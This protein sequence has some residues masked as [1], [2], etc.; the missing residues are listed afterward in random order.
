MLW[1][2]EPSHRGRRGI[3]VSGVIH[4]MTNNAYVFD[5]YL[6]SWQPKKRE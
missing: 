3:S 4:G 1:L 2:R 6:F 5:A